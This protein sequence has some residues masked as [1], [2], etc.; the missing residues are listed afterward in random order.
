MLRRQERFFDIL[1]ELEKSQYWEEPKI[2]ENQEIKLKKL[3]DYAYKT[4]PYYRETFNKIGLKPKH[5]KNLN[6]LKNLPIL[7][8]ETMR[9]NFD[10]L[11]SVGYKEKIYYRETTG[12]TGVPLRIAVDENSSIIEN[13]L[14]YRFLRWM[15]YDWGDKI[16]K[17]WGGKT[18]KS[19]SK[20][21]KEKISSLIYNEKFFDTYKIDEKLLMNLIYE[22]RKSPPKILRGYTSSIFFLAEKALEAGIKINLNAISPTAE[23]LFEYQRRRI[24][25]A[26]GKNIFDLYGCGET[27]SIAFECEKHEGLHVA[28]EHVIFEILNEKNQSCSSGKVVITNLDNY[29][30]PII[31]YENGDLAKMSKKKCSCDKNSP[32]I[33]KIEGR[34]YNVIEALNGRKV[35][36]GFLDVII[37]ELGLAE[38]YKVKEVRIIQER[39]DKLRFEILANKDLND[40]DKKSLKKLVEQYLGEMEMDIVRVNEI[41]DGKAGKRMFVI[42]LRTK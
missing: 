40:E 13:A 28:T 20:I 33:E 39:I 7:D 3:I 15:G 32:F 34:L 12:S 24:R 30:M 25:E 36:T 14:F 35:H 17:F 29:A 26:F 22:I 37:L 38:K 6:D 11:H 21:L 1:K 5:I 10:K 42:P 31:R 9:Q 23:K 27:N 16:F 8:K 19:K 4:V 18:V 2:K 41:P